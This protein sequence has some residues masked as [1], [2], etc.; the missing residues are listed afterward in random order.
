MLLASAIWA[1]LSLA[2]IL[3]VYLRMAL[4]ATL[5]MFILYLI[6]KSHCEIT[7]KWKEEKERKEKELL[8]AELK[9]PTTRT[10]DLTTPDE[11]KSKNK[12][13]RIPQRE[14]KLMQSICHDQAI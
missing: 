5:F 1:L 8:E 9:G 6:S 2:L 3:V 13:K 4:R 11:K 10:W 12:K 7:V 14:A